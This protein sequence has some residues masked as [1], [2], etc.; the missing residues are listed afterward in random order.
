MSSDATPEQN[1]TEGYLQ[2]AQLLA[3]LGRY[4]EAAGELGYAIALDPADPEPSIML[5]RVHLAAGRPAEALAAAETARAAGRPAA[6]PAAAETAPAAAGPVP[7][8]ALVTRGLALID[9]RRFRDAAQV[10]D[11]IL[12]RSPDDP[13]AQRSGA[14]IL[15]ESRNGQQALNAA[16]RGVELAPQDASAHLVL[17]VVAA[18][19]EL[20]DVAERAYREA[21]RLDPQLDEDDHDDV[22]IIR[23]E[24][25]RYSDALRLLAARAPIGP[26]RAGQPHPIGDG[27]RRLLLHGATYSLVAAVMVAFMASGAEWLSRLAAGLFAVGGGLLVWRLSTVVSGLV[28]RV[29]PKLR[30]VDGLLTGA[31]Y[32]VWGAPLLL[33]FYAL[34]GTPWPLVAAVV[35][36][37]AVEYVVLFRARLV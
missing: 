9:L 13:Y 33:L 16:W 8:A 14:A 28:D 21:L 2:R 30:R 27:L 15:A 10:A 19:L 12:V 23:L 32:G 31:V 36:T 20:F 26:P 22:G 29:L 35:V 34:V 18:R 7:T 11:E 4:D 6:A 24:Q 25:R 17:A 3:E 5:A 1:A 37:S